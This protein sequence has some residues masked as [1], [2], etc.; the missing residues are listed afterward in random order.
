MQTKILP[1]YQT[2]TIIY[3]LRAILK[4]FDIELWLKLKFD[5][6]GPPGSSH[7]GYITAAEHTKSW[8]ASLNKCEIRK[9]GALTWGLSWS[10]SVPVTKCWNIFDPAMAEAVR[11]QP[12]V[13]EAQDQSQAS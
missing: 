9:S 3:F 1:A 11:R 8:T 2:A 10:C 6:F 5:F 4:I 13:P 7:F 12:V